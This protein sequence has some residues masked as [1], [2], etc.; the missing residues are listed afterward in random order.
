MQIK[1][2]LFE[3]GFFLYV[4][5]VTQIHQESSNS[6]DLVTYQNMDA[7]NFDKNNNIII[8]LITNTNKIIIVHY[9]NIIKYH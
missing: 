3:D 9:C 7:P 2:S 4:S 5:T 1:N 6:L 8:I